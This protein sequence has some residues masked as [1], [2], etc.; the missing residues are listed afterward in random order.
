MSHVL[1][2]FEKQGEYT[3]QPWENKMKVDEMLMF[4]F[5]NENKAQN[6]KKGKVLIKGIIFFFN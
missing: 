5:P 3:V 2:Y 1:V 6:W 4:N